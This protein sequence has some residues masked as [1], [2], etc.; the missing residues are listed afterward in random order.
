[1]QLTRGLF[2]SNCT[3]SWEFLYVA[4]HFLAHN[5]ILNHWVSP[6]PLFEAGASYG[7]ALP[8]VSLCTPLTDGSR[9]SQGPIDSPAIHERD[10]ATQR[11]DACLLVLQGDSQIGAWVSPWGQRP[12]RCS[13]SKEMELVLKMCLESQ[14]LNQDWK[15]RDAPKLGIIK[16]DYSCK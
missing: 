9:D 3:I 14:Y 2:G 5:T 12:Q 8:H 15:F 11:F 10:K 1:M 7:L 6:W 13:P 4:N 16:N